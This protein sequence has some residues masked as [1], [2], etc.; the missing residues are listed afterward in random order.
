MK[1]SI[2]GIDVGGTKCAVIYG[3][4]EGSELH[5]VD[6]DKFQTTTVEETMENILTSIEHMIKK[7]ALANGNISAI[8]ISC[9]GPLDSKKGIIMS[10]PN[11]PGWDNI[12][13]VEIL[14]KRFGIKVGLQNDA[15]AGALA[16]WKYGA[17]RGTQNMVFMT[18]GT[19]LGAGLILNGNL[20]SGINN[21][22]GE[23]GHVRLSDYGPVGYG[24]AGSFEGF[25][26]G[27]GIAQIAKML[28]LEKNQMGIPINWCEPEEI[29]LLTA[30]KVAEEAFKG[31]PLARQVFDISAKE[32]GKGLSVVI[33]IL[34]PELI[35]IGG[36]YTRCQDLLEPGMLEVMKKEALPN[37]RHACKVVASQLNEHIGDYAALSVAADLL[38]KNR[39]DERFD[40]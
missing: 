31:D 8:G 7:H 6:K 17:G 40:T 18:F 2:L 4:M 30:Q 24:K 29:E 38:V 13:I 16:E 20:Y 37:S 11:L 3:Y 14:Q 35:V 19:G 25:C 22:A 23:I 34:N 33:D 12:P 27:G 28:L 15:D 32:L 26:S 36:I 5:L 1:K 10:P 39:Y 21:N 9:G